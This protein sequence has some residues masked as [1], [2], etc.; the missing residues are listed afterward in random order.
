LTEYRKTLDEHRQQLKAD[1][2]D[3][4]S[5]VATGEPLA[6]MISGKVPLVWAHSVLVYAVPT[7]SK[8]SAAR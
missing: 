5:R 3:Y 4:A 2:T 8:L 6:G 1:G 7:R